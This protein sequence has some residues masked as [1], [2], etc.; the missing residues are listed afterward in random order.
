M[1]ET[2]AS[3]QFRGDRI[4]L[5]RFPTCPRCGDLC[6]PYATICE[7]GCRLRANHLELARLRALHRPRIVPSPNL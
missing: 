5:D 7:C 4:A 3:R 2:A 1:S 6:E